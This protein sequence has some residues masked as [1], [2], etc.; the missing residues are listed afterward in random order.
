MAS[1]S[2]ASGIRKP[3]FKQLRIDGKDYDKKFKDAMYYVHYEISIKQ[4]KDESIKF[5]KYRGI[6]IPNISSLDNYWFTSI[7]KPCFISNKGGE[8]EDQWRDHVLSELNRLEELA[9]QKKKEESNEKPKVSRESSKIYEVTEIIDSI[10]DLFVCGE[11]EVSKV[12]PSAIIDDC[13]LSDDDVLKLRD[14]Y[15]SEISEL[16]MVL[17]G[18]DPEL[19]EGYSHMSKQNLRDLISFLTR[20]GEYVKTKKASREKRDLYK[21]AD[22]MKCCKSDPKFKIKGKS[23]IDIFG[24]KEVWILNTK[25]KKLAHYVSEDDIG[26]DIVSGNLSLF[27][28]DKSTEKSVRKQYSELS[29]IKMDNLGDFYGNID[30]LSISPNGK[31]TDSHLILHVVKFS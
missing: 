15:A 9:K 29:K 31:M 6:R 18:E 16:S 25:T 1:K 5:A 24:S 13:G 19:S 4:L 30:G 10:I 14:L 11:T 17:S 27:N 3:D 26:I 20:I 7:G 8:L 12:D 22:K 21:I 2:S 28:K 23:P